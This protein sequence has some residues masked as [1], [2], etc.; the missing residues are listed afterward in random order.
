MTEPA[1]WVAPAQ[2]YPDIDPNAVPDAAPLDEVE[3]G[4]EA[5]GS[6][7]EPFGREAS[8][9]LTEHV[10]RAN[11]GER[12]YA[13]NHPRLLALVFASRSKG[14]PHV[15]ALVPFD[16]PQALCTTCMSLLSLRERPQGCWAAQEAREVWGLADP[17]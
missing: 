5:P 4:S 1:R 16:P 13:P 10:T 9:S 6:T 7:L 11:A 15:V 2:Q 3:G 12:A 8:E 14:D 17:R